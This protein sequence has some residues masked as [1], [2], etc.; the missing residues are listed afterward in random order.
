MTDNYIQIS[1]D[2]IVILKIKT[3]DGKETGEELRFDVND[4]ELPLIYQDMMYKIK[5]NVEKLQND[6]IV[7]DKRQD[8]KGK[9]ILSKNQEDKIKAYNDFLKKQVEAYNMFLGK[10]GVEKLLNG[11]KLGWTTLDEI[12]DI[13]ANQIA[14]FITNIFGNIEDKIIGKYSNKDTGELK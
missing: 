4:I 9:K 12:D 6:F 5:K 8:I 1:D 2:E 7:I 3:K 13:I 10:N 11:R 14:P